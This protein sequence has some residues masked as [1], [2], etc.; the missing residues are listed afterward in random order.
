MHWHICQNFHKCFTY[1]LSLSFLNLIN[2]W[3]INLRYM[4]MT[5]FDPKYFMHFPTSN[6]WQLY[7][8][9]TTHLRYTI[10]PMCF[11]QTFMCFQNVMLVNTRFPWFLYKIKAIRQQINV[12][13]L[14][15]CQNHHGTTDNYKLLRGSDQQLYQV[16]ATSHMSQTLQPWNC[17]SPK[18]VSKQFQNH[19]VWSRT[20]KCS[21]KSYILGPQ[22]TAISMSCCSCGPS[23]W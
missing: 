14:N 2:Y 8:L 5:S 11:L 7:L 18:V 12:K 6:L 4:A 16:R 1:H 22:P 21:V 15:K 3:V 23:P 9:T 10:V 13:N 20:L 17:E 19:V